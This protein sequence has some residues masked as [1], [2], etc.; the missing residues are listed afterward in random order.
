MNSIEKVDSLEQ[1]LQTLQHYFIQAQQRQ[2][3]P[4]Q[5]WLAKLLYLPVAT[6]MRLLR[7]LMQP[8]QP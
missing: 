8:Y 6:R 4:R 3:E 5:S 1:D 7:E 2:R